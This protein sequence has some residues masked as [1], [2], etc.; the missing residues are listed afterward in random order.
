MEHEEDEMHKLEKGTQDVLIADAQGVDE[1]GEDAQGV[2]FQI[3]TGPVTRA[4]SKKLQETL[5][6]L[7][8]NV[9]EE[10]TK[11]KANSKELGLREET[12]II[13]LIQVQSSEGPIILG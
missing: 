1:L 8:G 5:Q 3:P 7:V 2:D 9:L 6:G 12:K 4:R 13:N 10:E 11:S